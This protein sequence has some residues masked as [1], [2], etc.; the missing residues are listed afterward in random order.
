MSDEKIVNTKNRKQTTETKTIKKE[1]KQAY[2]YLGPT[3]KGGILNN[4]SIYKEKPKH[5]KELLEKAPTIE[6]LFIEI[7]D[8]SKFKNDLTNQSTVAFRLYSKAINE[9]KEV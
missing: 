7:N 2:M 5:L 8:V 9:L 4:G 3:L 6:K 1:I